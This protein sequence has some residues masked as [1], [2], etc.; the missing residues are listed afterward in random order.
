MTKGACVSAVMLLT[1]TTV[2]LNYFKHTFRYE[3]LGHSHHM[4]WISFSFSCLALLLAVIRVVIQATS[5]EH[6][7]SR[8]HN[9]A[10]TYEGGQGGRRGGSEYSQLK[11]GYNESRNHAQSNNLRPEENDYIAN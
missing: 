2:V 11:G 4:A 8:H 10:V 7:Y 1:A 3:R 5:P 6:D 9:G